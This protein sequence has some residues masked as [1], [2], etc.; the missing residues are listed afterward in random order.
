[1]IVRPARVTGAAIAAALASRELALPDGHTLRTLEDRRDLTRAVER[2]GSSVWPEFMLHDVVSDRCWPRMA[3]DFPAFQMALVDDGG[4]VVAV[5]RSLP[6]AW[7]GTLEDL[8]HGWDEQFERSVAKFERSVAQFERRTEQSQRRTERAGHRTERS[9]RRTERSGR[10]TER[11][12]RRT[13]RAGR[14]TEQSEGARPPNTLGAIMIVTDPARRGDG[15]GSLMLGAMQ[16]AGRLHGLSTLVACVRPTLLERYPLTPIGEYA[17]WTRDDGLPFDPWIRIHV[18]LG[19]R[20]SRPEPASMRVS[21]S[22]DDWETWTG[23]AFP[24]SG[25]YVVPGACAPVRVD[26]DADTATYL[27]PNVWVIHDLA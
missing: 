24:A 27:D 3:A 6:L 21:A 4:G 11:S 26:R 20:L 13:E 25:E 7:D 12:G 9:G 2:L 17:R 8:P 14:R 19:G 22:I 10:R 15:L 1:M 16:E 23:M 18:R 5:G